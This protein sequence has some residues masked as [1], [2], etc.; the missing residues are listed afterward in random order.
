M[1]EIDSDRSLSLGTEQE[2]ACNPYFY[3]RKA[4]AREEREKAKRNK[5]NKNKLVVEEAKVT[6]RNHKPKKARTEN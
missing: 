6:E 2:R 5:R 3:T 4:K 1:Y